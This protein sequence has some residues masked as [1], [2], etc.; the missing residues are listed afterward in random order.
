[1]SAGNARVESAGRVLDVLLLLMRADFA[2]GLSPS[3]IA[4]ALGL[5]AS[6]VTRY[7]ATLEER[8][9]LERLTVT[10]RVRPS[11][12]LAQYAVGILRS[13]ESATQRTQELTA[14]ITTPLN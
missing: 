8:G 13:L 3:D 6:A 2:A 10:G 11:V 14:R 9:C 5:S 12:R 1:M 7:L 4:R